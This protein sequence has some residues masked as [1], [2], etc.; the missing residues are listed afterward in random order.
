MGGAAASP[1]LRP[2]SQGGFKM[3]KKLIT[4]LIFLTTIGV[5]Q[6]QKLNFSGFLRNYTGVL[7]SLDNEFA[8]I[9]NTFNL[10]I[11]QNRDKIAFKFNPYVNQYSGK[12]IEFGVREAYLDIYF[13]SVDVRIGKQQIIWG[14]ADGVFITDIVSPKDLRE[15]I[16]PDF[17]EVRMGITSVKAD[18]YVGDNTFEVVWIPA[19]VP[20]KFPEPGSI[21]KPQLPTF[22]AP[23]R[24]D[25]S[26]MVVEK[27]LENSEFFAKFS[28]L[29][30]LVDFELMAGY[31]W[32]DDPV[33]HVVK[34]VTRLDSQRIRL[35]SLT[36]YPEYHRLEI[37][38][39]SFSTTLGPV[40]LRG[41]GAFYSGKY[42]NTQDPGALES[43][44]EKNYLHYL[45]GVDY[46][47]M[48]WHLSG[49]FIQR[50][51]LDYEDSIKEDEFSSMATFLADKKFW[52]ET[53][54][55]KFFA[56]Y[57]FNGE[58]S[59]L[60]PSVAYDL[61]DGFNILVGANVFTGTEGL[62]GQFTNNDM[63]YVKVKYSF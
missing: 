61:A 17:D 22:P 62:F 34:H 58:S 54:D 45:V 24:F 36:L 2:L 43:V 44:V 15:F 27:S 28:V 29:S 5:I 10:N 4:A 46:T 1:P 31:A 49:Q 32:D 53:L 7:V 13:P 60:R 6:A 52:N 42:F 33:I 56:Y 57:D 40:V 25:S 47:L 38:G 48:G 20:D 39:G 23:F 37:G 59:L 51:I 63:V 19:F 21:W 55:I 16:L 14:K 18:Y 9:Q 26:R 3:N 35:D 30:R 41:E 50:A 11:E 8:I 12:N